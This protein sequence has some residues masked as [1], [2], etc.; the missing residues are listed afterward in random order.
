MTS[1]PLLTL[2]VV[3][4]GQASLIRNLLADLALLP[5][6]SL[7]VVLTINIPE[8]ESAYGA[9]P[10]PVCLI[11]NS[12]PKGFG[13]NHNAAFARC[14][15][16]FFAVVNPDI[17]IRTL[18]TGTLLEP[19]DRSD[20]GATAPIILST[21]GRIQ[22]SVRRFP[23]LWRLARRILLRK[24]VPDYRWGQ[25][26]IEVDWAAGMFVVFRRDAFSAIHGFDEKRYFMYFEDVDIC[27]RLWR[28]GWSVLLQ[29]KVSVFH[30]AQRASRRSIKHLRW[31]VTSA[32]RYLGDL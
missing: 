25:D 8:D 3:S 17:R 13:A 19:F 5:A 4:H 6:Q 7:D 2:S 11:R 1:G 21:E 26:P 18:D 27:A 29:P 28:N 31:H 23:T 12:T 30:D 10:F 22:D 24:R 16:P 9:Q 15:S 14:R 20:V 32:V